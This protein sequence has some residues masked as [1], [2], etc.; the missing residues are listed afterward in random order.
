MR[1]TR[2]SVL[3]E[4]HSVV[5]VV[6]VVQVNS[7]ILTIPRDWSIAFVYRCT[8]IPDFKVLLHGGHFSLR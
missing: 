8:C 3:A 1:W 5:V 6:V 4:V 2:S 7:H